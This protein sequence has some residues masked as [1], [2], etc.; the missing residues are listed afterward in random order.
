MGLAVKNEQSPLLEDDDD[1]VLAIMD[2]QEQGIRALLERHGPKV[3]GYLNTKYGPLLGQDELEFILHG[4]VAAAWEKI[5]HFDESKG[6]L[7]GWFFTIAR[8]Q[9]IDYF[10]RADRQIT[11]TVEDFEASPP[12]WID[13]KDQDDRPALSPKLKEALDYTI[14]NA[15]SPQQK[16]VIYA[17]MAAGG[18]ADN[19]LL[20]TKLGTS[21]S[22]VHTAR[23]KAHKKI[24]NA[25]RD[26]R[27]DPT[28]GSPL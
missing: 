2:G 27:L 8:N 19:S 17:D 7:G 14:E 28:E 10:R 5:D 3:K 6:E 11:E 15:L 25:L 24:G 20:A 23:S 26:R 1:I 9:A 4:A 12:L 13:S 18:Q 16:E 22:A 21:V